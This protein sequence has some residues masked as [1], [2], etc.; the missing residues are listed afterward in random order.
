MLTLYYIPGISRKDTPVFDSIV[1][2][3]DYFRLTPDIVHRIDSGFY[4]PHYQN[5]IELSTEDLGFNQ[6]Y[7]YLSLE[8]GNK[9]YYYFI[10]NIR[11]VNESVVS[12][13]I[14]MDT[15][16]TY[17]FDI[18]FIQSHLTRH[19]IHRW[20][21]TT[22]INRNYLRE[23]FTEGKFKLIRKDFIK[24]STDIGGDDDL[25]T[26]VII[27][28]TP[29]PDNTFSDPYDYKSNQ[30]FSSMVTRFYPVIN[31]KIPETVLINP[32]GI[33]AVVTDRIQYRKGIVRELNS[34][35]TVI[36]AYY[37]PFMPFDGITCEYNQ[38]KGLYQLNYDNTKYELQMTHIDDSD[39]RQSKFEAIFK[40]KAEYTVKDYFAYKSLPFSIPATAQAFSKYSVPALIDETYLNVQFGEPQALASFPLHQMT[41]VD[42]T[43]YYYGDPHSGKR[44]YYV[45][46]DAYQAIINAGNIPDLFGSGAVASNTPQLDINTDAYKEYFTYN[47][48][49][50]VAGA[51]TTVAS[52]AALIAMLV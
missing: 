21:S 23:N 12:I 30:G 47:K 19:S 26:G 27:V 51:V 17:M 37:M 14:T 8:V 1:E 9:K 6:R 52:V 40:P 7:N 35:A 15:V 24:G 34:N 39:P 4:P 46:P 48:G 36:Y 5:V 11:Y 16:Q 45:C 18:Q 38:S 13:S 10:D 41:T 42:F 28:K 2:Q 31:G 43:A 33:G 29:P 20:L 25:I 44:Y 3:T 49:G 22:D 50:A 32:P